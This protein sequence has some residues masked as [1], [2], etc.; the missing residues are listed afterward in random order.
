MNRLNYGTREACQRLVKAG[1]VL[2]TD[3]IYGPRGDLFYKALVEVRPGDIPALSMAE[4]WR[5][6]P[7]F[8]EY[9]GRTYNKC[10][11]GYNGLNIAS[12][13]DNGILNYNDL[14]EST[15]PVDALIDLK[16][17]LTAQKEGV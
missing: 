1:I 14:C 11:V 2:E 12:Y 8:I 17:W 16:I 7:E 6:L 9:K 15:N 4:V 10:L 13:D 5:E 3:C